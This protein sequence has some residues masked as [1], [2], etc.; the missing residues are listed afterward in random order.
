MPTIKGSEKKDSPRKIINS[1]IQQQGISIIEKPQKF[2]TLFTGMSKGKFNRELNLLKISFIENIPNEIIKNKNSKRIPQLHRKLALKLYEAYGVDLNIAEW[3]VKS[4]GLALTSSQNNSVEDNK[5]PTASTNTDILNQQL[6]QLDSINE[7]EFIGYDL[8][9][10]EISNEVDDALLFIHDALLLENNDLI[11]NNGDKIYF[12]DAI[13][14]KEKKVFGNNKGKV[15]PPVISDGIIYFTTN[16]KFFAKEIES[17]KVNWQVFEP[18]LQFSLPPVI[19]NNF[20]LTGCNDTSICAFDVKTGEKKWQFKAKD[21]IQSSL[22]VFDGIVYFG[23]NDY[24]LYALD[25][26]SG[27][28]LWRFGFEQEA[29]LSPAASEDI[30]YYGCFDKFYAFKAISGELLWKVTLDHLVAFSPIVSDEVVFISCW[31]NT[32]IAID[33]KMGIQL[34]QYQLDNEIATIPVFSNDIIYIADDDHNLHAINV[35]SGMRIWKLSLS[36]KIICPLVISNQ[37][38]Y[39][40]SKNGISAIAIK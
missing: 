19:S 13:S 20:I 26:K 23:S 17:G 27:E 5:S 31:G 40:K 30:V 16:D 15:F 35:L 32:L 10:F 25:T 22:V 36:E 14:G 24:S 1:I 2:L 33:S 34:W 28:E 4:W 38:L 29:E 7:N 6:E 8:W 12:V 39:I 37:I 11:F 21:W 18:E 9:R 3:V